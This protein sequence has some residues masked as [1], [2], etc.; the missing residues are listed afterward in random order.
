MRS[1]FPE[2]CSVTK[3]KLGLSLGTKVK[4]LLHRTVVIDSCCVRVELEDIDQERLDID[5]GLFSRL[6]KVPFSTGVLVNNSLLQQGQNNDLCIH[7]RLHRWGR[8]N[9]LSREQ[10]NSKDGISKRQLR[11]YYLSLTKYVFV[12]F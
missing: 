11:F 4:I 2:L 10:M 3:P 12:L 7:D 1:E 9:Y 8:P 5:G 6:R